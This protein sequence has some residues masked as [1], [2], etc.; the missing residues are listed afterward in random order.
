MRS[1]R[2]SEKRGLIRAL[3]AKKQLKFHF[4][5]LGFRSEVLQVRRN[6]LM[7]ANRQKYEGRNE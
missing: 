2:F 7:V 3:G 1:P 6:N 4:S 5:E